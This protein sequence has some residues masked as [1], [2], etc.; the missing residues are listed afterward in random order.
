MIPTNM[1]KLLYF[2]YTQYL[3]L[4]RSAA[5]LANFISQFYCQKNY[6][7]LGRPEYF[8]TRVVH[9]KQIQIMLQKLKTPNTTQTEHFQSRG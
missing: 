7:T 9:V 4:L 1:K 3:S 5:F 8:R 2:I 6:S